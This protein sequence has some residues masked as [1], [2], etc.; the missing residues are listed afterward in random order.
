MKIL[1]LIFD[2]FEEEEAMAPF[3]LL[4]RAGANLTIA[5]LNK[6]HFLSTGDLQ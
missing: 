4:R 5:S 6:Y 2:G 1:A 3:A